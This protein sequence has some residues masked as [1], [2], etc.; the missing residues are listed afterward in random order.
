[1]VFH[2]LTFFILIVSRW[3]LSCN[4]SLCVGS[5]ICGVCFCHYLFT[6]FHALGR[7]CFVIVAFPWSSLLFE[8]VH[9]KTYNKTCATSEDLDQNPD[10]SSLIRV[11]ADRM[12]L[13]SLRTIQGRINENPVYT[14][15]MY[16]LICVFAG[17]NDLIISNPPPLRNY[18]G[19]APAL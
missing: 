9:D 8:P 15:W 18:L 17:H 16:R 11:L 10:P 6:F 4:S 14:G 7:L 2:A 5:F 1:M 19:S 13:Y 12:Y 3:F